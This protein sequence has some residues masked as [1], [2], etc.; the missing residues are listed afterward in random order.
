MTSYIRDTLKT[1][2]ALYV[3]VARQRLCKHV[4]TVTTDDVLDVPLS[5]KYVW[6][7]TLNA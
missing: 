4:S 5:V 1:S 2:H 6:C 7:Q 3:K